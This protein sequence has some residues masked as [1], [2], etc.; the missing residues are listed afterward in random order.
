LIDSEVQF[1]T[2]WPGLGRPECVQMPEASIT[3]ARGRYH[4]CP[5][6][7][8]HCPRAGITLLSG[9]YPGPGWIMLAPAGWRCNSGAAGFRFLYRFAGFYDMHIPEKRYATTQKT[10]F[11]RKKKKNGNVLKNIYLA[12]KIF[13]SHEWQQ[14]MVQSIHFIAF[15]NV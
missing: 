13:S 6:P 15:C 11:G 10:I 8:S 4:K 1:A 7:V 9:R 2:S 5:R 14:Q 3:N 12:T